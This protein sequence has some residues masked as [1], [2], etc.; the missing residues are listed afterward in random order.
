V[1]TALLMV[2]N[3]AAIGNQQSRCKLNQNRTGEEDEERDC[4][5]HS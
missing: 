4:S 2:N 3:S 1:A 5:F